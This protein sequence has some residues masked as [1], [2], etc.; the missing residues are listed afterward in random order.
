MRAWMSA[1]LV[2]LALGAVEHEKIASGAKNLVAYMKPRRDLPRR[3]PVTPL[4]DAHTGSQV[5][6][7]RVGDHEVAY[8]AD[9]DDALI[10]I[11]DTAGPTE[12]GTAPLPGRP[13]QLLVLPDGRVVAAIRGG[14]EVV[15]LRIVTGNVTQLVPEASF[16]TALEPIGLATTPD[17][18][19]L[20]I[21]S[22]WG[23]SLA[24]LDVATGRE[25][26][27]LHLPRDPRA[28]VT[29]ADGAKAYVSHA[30]G[31]HVSVVD[32]AD[33]GHSVIA[34]SVDGWSTENPLSFGRSMMMMGESFSEI[35]DREALVA[36]QPVHHARMACQGFALARIDGPSER[37][38]V[39][40]VQVETGDTTVRSGG[41]GSGG[42][43][44]TEMPNVAVLP[45]D[46]G[47][48]DPRSMEVFAKVRSFG[49][50]FD[51]GT[52]DR[53]ELRR[54][55]PLTPCALPRA[56]T[57]GGGSLFVAC[58]GIDSVV[59]Y[60]ADVVAPERVEHR[61]WHV[62]SGPQGLSLVGDRL[63]V[64]SQFARTLT[65]L[66]VEKKEDVDL[67]EAD[68][69]GDALSL[70][71]AVAEAQ[72]VGLSRKPALAANAD[73]ELGRQLFHAS[74]DA[75]IS[76][77]GRACASCHPDGRDDSL[78]WSTPGG[79][80]QTPMLAG[81]LDDTAPYGWDGA[82][83]DVATHLQHTFQRLLGRGLDSNETAALVA[84][85][86]T[87]PVPP[88][89][90][91]KED[92]AVARGATLFHSKEAGCSSCHSGDTLTDGMAHDLGTKIEADAK[93][94]FDTPSLRFVAGTAPYFHDGRYATLRDVLSH[95]DGAMGHT[96]Q[97][98]PEDLDALEAYVETL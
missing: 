37:V 8:V 1:T 7:A 27:R 69:A 47:I 82:G 64:W 49:D 22:G 10:H 44:A 77:D 39:P 52:P 15:T 70:R 25:S 92:P 11:V 96:G 41:Y 40:Q 5:V 14:A 36:S 87:L 4:G 55:S 34:S 83:K 3:T 65:V 76:S 32:L 50:R 91:K 58:L 57:T 30:V 79:P 89:A 56:A 94:D 95:T 60:D 6:L 68:R 73:V 86:R 13:G 81:R 19:T 62:P 66:D 38:L 88:H 43:L 97:L 72:R 84:Y 33:P 54:E 85:M 17:G 74:S 23:Q 53:R 93:D 35:P 51:P 46:T 12:I 59:E 61:R 24:I 26:V 31:S 67:E 45:V 98:S 78:T 71:V 2:V 29:S 28:V 16:P 80:R 90:Q 75:R 48:A 9:E 63:Y 42:G 18:K 21:T 20:L